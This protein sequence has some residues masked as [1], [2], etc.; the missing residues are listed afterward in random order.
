M[1]YLFNSKSN[2]DEEQD[3]SNIKNMEYK[4]VDELLLDN[5]EIDEAS[6]IS[7]SSELQ[8][9]SEVNNID[10]QKPMNADDDTI[11]DNDA[12]EHM[13]SMHFYSLFSI[14]EYDYDE[15]MFVVSTP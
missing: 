4:V 8:D 11:R 9:I 12:K 3:S 6:S 15:D 1:C 13:S 5:K 10:K 14:K 7:E 2:E